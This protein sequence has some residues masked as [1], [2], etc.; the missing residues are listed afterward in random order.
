MLGEAE[1]GPNHSNFRPRGVHAF[2]AI[3]HA[4]PAE[5]TRLVTEALLET[6]FR[7]VGFKKGFSVPIW[8]AFSPTSN[9]ASFRRAWR[10]GVDISIFTGEI[11]NES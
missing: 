10:N 2:V 9:G 4:S 6:G 1:A 7:A 8:R 5:A 11:R 3:A